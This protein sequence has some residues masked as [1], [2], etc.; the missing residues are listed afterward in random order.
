MKHRIFDEVLDNDK[1]LE[2][3]NGQKRD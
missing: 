3:F 2:V 1:F